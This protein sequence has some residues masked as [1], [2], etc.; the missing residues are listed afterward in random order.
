MVLLIFKQIKLN[1]LLKYGLAVRAFKAIL[2]CDLHERE[3]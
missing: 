2:E 3:G 1:E